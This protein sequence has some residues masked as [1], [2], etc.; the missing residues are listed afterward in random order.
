MTDAGSSPEV[1]LSVILPVRDWPVDR[2]GI[3]IRSFL[4]LNS[5]TLDEIV[6]VDFGSRPAVKLS[7][8]DKRV[9][10]VRVEAKRWSLAEAINVG[11]AACRNPVVAKVD[12]DIVVSRESGPGLDAAAARCSEPGGEITVVQAV[13]LPEVLD[14]KAVLK[15]P[16]AALI[17][18]GR[19]RPRWG[20]GGLCLFSAED[21]NDIGDFDARYH[22]WGN[23]DN[24]FVD[25]MR[26]S[27]RAVRWAGDDSL[28]IFHVWHPP[29]Y[30]AKDIVK[31]RSENR[32]IYTEDRS[33]FRSIRFLASR[34][35]GIPT[36]NVVNSPRPLV[37]VAIA[38]KARKNRTSMLKEAIRG[39]VG[40]IDG[41]FEFVIADNGSSAEEREHL[42]QTVDRLGRRIQARVLHLDRASIPAARNRITDE[43]RG[44]YICVADDDDIPLPNRLRDHL[45]CFESEADIHGSHGG[46]IDFDELT[47]VTEYNTGGERTLATLLFGRGKVTAH[48]ASFYR[49]DVLKAVRYDEAI[50]AGSDLDLAV[51]MANLGCRIAHTGSYVTLRRFHETNITLTDLAG[52][53][54]IGVSGRHRVSQ[55]LGG[56]YENH[57]RETAKEATSEIDCR[58]GMCRDRLIA[59]M[60]G[61]TGV[62]RLLIP[63]S[64]LARPE[65]DDL[66]RHPTGI[67]ADEAR[68]ERRRENGSLPLVQAEGSDVFV[69]SPPSEV[70]ATIPPQLVERAG[71]IG[72]LL[73]GDVG[74]VDVGISPDLF[75]VSGAV[76]GAARALKMR[77]EVEQRFGIAA[78]L[79]PRR[80][81]STPPLDAFR[82]GQANRDGLATP[83]V[84]AVQGPRSRPHRT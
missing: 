4:R 13:D 56:A 59:L 11:V 12:A 74:V 40:Q 42:R 60:P 27:G 72:E 49:K 68:P 1:M 43:S 6:V 52:Q 26:R 25:R 73:K 67:G 65:V 37:T 66:D 46:W 32:Q 70:D 51:R 33:T 21:W 76:K 35:R 23:E 17:R 22:G 9:R 69:P 38:S 77:R 58:N 47:G 82:L 20:Q 39:F 84:A 55:T 3:C 36:P 83:V 75:V 19:R 30:A 8:M 50:R 71:M 15:S 61:Y 2:I 48:P 14:S 79:I 53:L 29:S 41:D 31:A 63:V 28:R 34:S 54:E 44:R 18:Q 80:R 57:L 24:D 5:A 10:V 7:R 81:I 45:A 78:E 62:W 64:E 16:T